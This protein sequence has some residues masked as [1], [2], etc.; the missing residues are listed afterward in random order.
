MAFTRTAMTVAVVAGLAACSPDG[1]GARSNQSAM[2]PEVYATALEAFGLAEQN[3]RVS[4]AALDA[5]G[6]VFRFTD[7]TL[8]D[9]DGVLTVDTFT[10]ERPELSDDGPVFDG[11]VFDGG[12]ISFDEGTARF[13]RFS[14]TDAGPAVADSF[15]ALVQGRDVIVVEDNPSD[16]GFGGFSVSNLQVDATTEEGNPLT[17]SLAAMEAERFD[18]EALDRFRLDTLSLETTNANKDVVTVSVAAVELDGFGGNIVGMANAQ[19]FARGLNIGEAYE[20]F[21]VSELLVNSA[22][23]RVTM[24]E[25]RGDTSTRSENVVAAIISMPELVISAN[26]DGGATGAQVATGLS[27]AGF[28]A[29]HFSLQSTTVYDAAEDRVRTEGENALIL[30]DGF[31]LSVD[32]DFSGVAAYA[33]AYADWLA[34]APEGE[35]SPPADVLALLALNR[36]VIELEDEALLDNLFASMAAERGMS[37]EAMRAQASGLV[38]FASLLA[39]DYADRA[40]IQTAQGALMG[41]VASGGTLTIAVEPEEPLEMSRFS[42]GTLPSD[43]GVSIT[44]SPPR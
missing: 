27:Q 9:E 5:D 1:D 17:M 10:F 38:A 29:L 4:W 32:Q 6:G 42:D 31:R 35:T 18:G 25:L 37:P 41:F 16:Q 8:T 44:H 11:L 14:V 39:S 28:E 15:A 13:D 12:Q 19:P 36:F 7:F 21:L 24:P 40:L 20:R 22:G 2:S 26:P 34:N 30:R 43:A 33:E 23:L 3:E